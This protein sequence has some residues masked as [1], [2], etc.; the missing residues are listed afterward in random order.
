MEE[1]YK[2]VK[3]WYDEDRGLFVATVEGEGIYSPTL[4]DMKRKLDRKLSQVAG[5]KKFD[6]WHVEYETMLVRVKVTS[7]FEEARWGGKS[8]VRA[9]ITAKEEKGTGGYSRSECGIGELLSLNTPMKDVEQVMAMIKKWKEL[10]EL[11]K[12]AV[13]RLPRITR[14]ELYPKGAPAEEPE[15]EK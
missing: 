3:I 10:G 14:E 8:E 5:F 15:E 6:A 13:K 9:R 2:N 1:N 12:E 4:K 11:I 7:V